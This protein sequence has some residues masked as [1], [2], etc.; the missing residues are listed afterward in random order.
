MKIVIED[1]E[2]FIQLTAQEQKYDIAKAMAKE[3][4]IE[5]WGN[6]RFSDWNSGP[7]DEMA[8]C[9][10]GDTYWSATTEAQK[11][12]CIC[13]DAYGEVG[14]DMWDCLCLD[15]MTC[16]NCGKKPIMPIWYLEESM[17]CDECW[18]EKEKIVPSHSCDGGCKAV[19]A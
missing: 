12:M 6:E 14:S 7:K 19:S 15:E 11:E 9:G 17:P 5:D 2:K 18:T 3:K 8:W 13:F 16:M 10:C 1:A 4:C